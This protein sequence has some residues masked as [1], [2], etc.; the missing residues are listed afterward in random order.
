MLTRRGH[1]RRYT[2]DVPRETLD[3]KVIHILY[4]LQLHT[5]KVIQ[6]RKSSQSVD[7]W[8]ES[9]Q[10]CFNADFF[11]GAR[12]SF[13]SITSLGLG[14]DTGEGRRMWGAAWR[15]GRR[16]RHASLCMMPKRDV[17]GTSR[18]VEFG[19]HG[20]CIS[21]MQY[22]DNVRKM[23]KLTHSRRQNSLEYFAT[24]ALKFQQPPLRIVYHFPLIA[25]LVQARDVAQVHTR[26]VRACCT[27]FTTA[28]I[29]L[30]P[31]TEPVEQDAL[32]STRSLCFQRVSFFL[33]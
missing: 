28:S 32:P 12:G 6:K 24:R 16:K 29:V 14:G 33:S 7:V 23:T 27:E 17:M 25:C 15:C 1:H 30:C 9:P 13:L 21:S 2:T 10:V 4:T 22:L 11:E 8:N 18:P 5:R 19:N 20:A 26:N 31:R 3:L